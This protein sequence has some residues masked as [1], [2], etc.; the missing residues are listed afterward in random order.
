MSRTPLY[1]QAQAA[2]KQLIVD[3]ELRPGDPLPSEAELAEE[4]GMS[5]LSLRE[6]IKSLESMG[7]V[8]SKHG[9]GLFV[10]PFSFTPLVENLPYGQYI[11]GGDL[12]NLLEVREALE[13]AMVQR[14]AAVATEGDLALLQ[15]LA[16]AMG[17]T[18]DRR[19]IAD[20]DQ[21]F[22]VALMRPLQNPFVTDLVNV[23]WLMFSRLRDAAQMTGAPGPALRE[24]HLAIVDALRS[25][26][27]P[28]AA[29]AVVAHFDPLR[30]QLA[31]LD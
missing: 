16:E 21:R 12:R 7:V 17:D 28:G 29:A 27:G 10:A 24:R 4:L 30:E 25:G 22:H 2:I 6:G 14:L 3:R 23:F 9:D 31:A 11:G 19:R 1:R 26:S 13:T 18:T 5:R 15:E 20:L 8:A